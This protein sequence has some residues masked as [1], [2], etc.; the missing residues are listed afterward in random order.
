MA[1]TVTEA[2][3][4]SKL[5]NWLLAS[6][7]PPT[8]KTL[9]LHWLKRR[10]KGKWMKVT[11]GSPTVP[12]IINYKNKY[13]PP[14]LLPELPTAPPKGQGVT[15]LLFHRHPNATSPSTPH[16]IFLL[17]PSPME[18]QASSINRRALPRVTYAPDSCYV[19][20]RWKIVSPITA[21]GTYW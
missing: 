6:F 5:I 21:L 2:L 4:A 13:T 14:P 10:V 20:G 3:S 1:D 17:P 19:I 11:T 9:V 15:N 18:R 8:E 7:L 16:A 12:Y